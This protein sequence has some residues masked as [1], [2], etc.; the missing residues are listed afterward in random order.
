ME[1]QPALEIV[2]SR[3]DS[4][5]EIPGGFIAR[6]PVAAHNDRNPSLKIGEGSDGRVLLKCW[7]GCEVLE[8][9]KAIGLELSDLFERDYYRPPDKRQVP[10][11]NWRDVIQLLFHDATVVRLCAESMLEG[12]DI[13]SEDYIDLDKAYHSLVEI[14]NT[15]KALMMPKRGGE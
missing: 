9:V 5:Q 13:T 15:T 14:T 12:K 2:L 10:R 7:A 6:C 3:L 11:P 4:V 8:I 1:S